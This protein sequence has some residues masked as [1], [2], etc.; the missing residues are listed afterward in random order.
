MP[1]R[2]RHLSRATPLP[3]SHSAGRRPGG[4]AAKPSRQRAR[5]ALRT[6]GFDQANM[7]PWSAALREGRQNCDLE[8]SACASCRPV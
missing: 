7:M 1:G 8:A 3:P 4:G 6:S 5:S 2:E